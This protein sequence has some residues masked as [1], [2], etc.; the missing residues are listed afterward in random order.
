MANVKRERDAG[1]LCAVKAR[2]ETG[3]DLFRGAAVIRYELRL[4]QMRDATNCWASVKH[5]EDGVVAALLPNGD[6]PKSGYTF[7]PATQVK[8]AHRRD[9]GVLVTIEE[10]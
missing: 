7:L 2:N 5:V 4:C 10:P 9:Q 8:V 3:T 6:G 1:Y